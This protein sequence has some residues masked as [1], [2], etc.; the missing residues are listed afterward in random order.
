MKEQFI[1]IESFRL[2]PTQGVLPSGGKTNAI[3]AG[4]VKGEFLK[5]PI[6]L[7]WLSAAAKLPGK[8][9]LAV[10]LAI[11]F[12]SGR[13]RSD[14]IILTS[15]VLQRFG[16]NRKAKYRGLARLEEANLIRV[17]RLSRRNPVVTVIN[18][19]ILEG[20]PRGGRGVPETR[21]DC[22]QLSLSTSNGD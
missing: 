7:N 3:H 5:G 12:E 6:P 13:R 4:R 16:V 19:G 9:P 14:E 15:A 20:V 18:G 11:K 22:P 1:D 2:S 10:A 17:H 21:E 8:A